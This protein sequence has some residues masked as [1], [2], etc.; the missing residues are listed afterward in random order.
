MDGSCSVHTAT[1]TCGKA[2]IQQQPMME[3]CPPFSIP[4]NQHHYCQH[5]ATNTSANTTECCSS[6]K[7][8]KLR[9][10]FCVKIFHKAV[11]PTPEAAV[12]CQ[13]TWPKTITTNKSFN[14]Q[15]SLF[16]IPYT[17]SVPSLFERV[18]AFFLY[19]LMMV[20]YKP[21]CST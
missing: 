8:F 15:H 18:S 14:I 17:S 4:D 7:M 5:T 10:I 19:S 21:L 12:E 6:F 11:M 13:I 1:N 9:R 20:F 16:N 2:T 3:Y